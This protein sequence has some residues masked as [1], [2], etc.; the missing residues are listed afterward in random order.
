[1]A[2]ILSDYLHSPLSGNLRR[3]IEATINAINRNKVKFDAIAFRGM[4]GALVSPAV[5]VRLRKLLIMCREEYSNTHSRHLV[6]G[7]TKVNK[8]IIIDDFIEEGK[9]IREIMKRL[10]GRCMGVFLY[11]S[12]SSLGDIEVNG[13]IY[14]VFTFYTRQKR[15]S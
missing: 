12:S 5:A 15:V 8:Y 10:P 14:P 1:M 11:N 4:S 3:K 7:A 2:S 9:T 6:E 13:K